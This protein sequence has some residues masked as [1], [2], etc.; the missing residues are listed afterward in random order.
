[1]VGPSDG[2]THIGSCG[3]CAGLWGNG[4]QIKTVKGKIILVSIGHYVACGEHS[5]TTHV[6]ANY[7]AQKVTFAVC[8]TAPKQAEN[9][10]RWAGAEQGESGLAGTCF[11]GRPT[12]LTPATSGRGRAG[13]QTTDSSRR[14][15]KVS[16]NS[17]QTDP[18][19]EKTGPGGSPKLF[20]P[21]LNFTPLFFMVFLLKEG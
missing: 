11:S 1:M 4:L 13:E 3:C 18:Q 2:Q 9:R 12:A 5:C 16:K 7:S 6:H 17:T 10:A 14:R 21:L 15:Q 19:F 8:W 20:F